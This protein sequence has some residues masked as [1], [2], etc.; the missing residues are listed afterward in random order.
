M[1]QSAEQLPPNY[2][3]NFRAFAIDFVCFMMAMLFISSNSVLPAFVRELT[4][5]AILIG[6][7]GTIFSGGWFLPQL[8]AA[9]LVSDMP[10]KMPFIRRAVPGRGLFLIVA[11]ALWIGL[12][13]HPTAMLIIFFACLF[14]FAVSDG[15]VS[16]PWYDILARTIPANRRGRLFGLSQTIQGIA[17]IGIGVIIS[18]VL[19]SGDIAFPNNYIILFLAASALL[20]PS[21]FVL[22]LIKEPPP[23]HKDGHVKSSR[24]LNWRTILRTD[25]DYRR[26]LVCRILFNMS[27][28]AVPFFVGHAEDILSLPSSILGAFV[29]AQTLSG[30]IASVVYGVISDRWGPRHVVRIATAAGFAAP[31]FALVAHLTQGTWTTQAYPFVYAILGIANN[32]FMLGFGNY[33]LA[34]SPENERPTYVG[35]CNTILGIMTIVPTLG[36]WLLESTSYTFLFCLAAALGIAGFLI[37]LKLR[38]SSQLT[39]AS[40]SEPV[41]ST[42]RA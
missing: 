36:G 22:L 38:D 42:A 14:L 29:I 31:C 15:L 21:S 11:G 1:K 32:A 34:I 6:L 8:A 26:F 35:L 41:E 2:R 28:L 19:G 24:Q 25:P 13:E 40:P 37:A 3:W 18:R 7:A 33:L 4:D 5:S 39:T 23:M 12:A 30:V 17:G 27:F 16:V 9:R 20:I 10:V